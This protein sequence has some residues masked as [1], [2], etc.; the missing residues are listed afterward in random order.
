[1]FKYDVKDY[2]KIYDKCFSESFCNDAVAYLNLQNWT[3]HTME[4]YNGNKFTDDTE[5]S[6]FYDSDSKYT[7]HIFPIIQKAIGKYILE[8]FKD[9]ANW[10][11]GWNNTSFP[12][13]N[14][15]DI[16]TQMKIH[17]DHIHSL[18]DGN[19][20][21]VPVL[22]ILG[23]LNNNYTGGELILFDEL[24]VKLKAGQIMIFP[25]NFMYPHKVLPVKSGVRY[26]F[27]SW[28]W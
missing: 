16:N 2:V 7:K 24:S 22:T 25:S 18:F 15:Y 12:R 26:T 17:C 23:S 10:F 13:Y 28:A 5:L 14:R 11:D 21:G 9:Y 8:D 20:K 4:D 6:N 27:V 1:M 19:Q 3:K